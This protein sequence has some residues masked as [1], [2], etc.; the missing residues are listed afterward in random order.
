MVTAILGYLTHSEHKM[1]GYTQLIKGIGFLLILKEPNCVFFSILMG[2][3]I[4]DPFRGRIIM[5]MA[6]AFDLL[7]MNSVGLGALLTSY[8]M[9]KYLKF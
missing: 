2:D 5:L 3:G 6:A 7:R 8:G 4:K 1:S 9:V